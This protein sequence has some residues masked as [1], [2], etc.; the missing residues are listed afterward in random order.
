MGKMKQ[1]MFFF[2]K[3]L[4]KNNFFLYFI[5]ILL[6]NFIKKKKTAMTV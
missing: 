3:F 5:F 1:K 2:I 4:D 6:I